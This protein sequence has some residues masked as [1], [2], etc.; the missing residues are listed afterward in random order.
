MS[1]TPPPPRPPHG[2]PPPFSMQSPPYGA[3]PEQRIDP[4]SP[5]PEEP[6]GKSERKLK[7]GITILGF[8]SALLALTTGILAAVTNSTSQ[9][10]ESLTITVSQANS[11]KASAEA[12]VSAAQ[13]TISSLQSQLA[14]PTASPSGPVT[15]TN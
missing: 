1:T 15:P 3:P 7:V 5:S 12:S 13:S 6:D 8:L 2:A 9:K 14:Q 10:N 4:T 11:A